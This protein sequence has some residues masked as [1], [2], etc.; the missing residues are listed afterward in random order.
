[1]DFPFRKHSNKNKK[2]YARKFHM[3]TVKFK[4]SSPP[5]SPSES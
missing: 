5:V 1:M 3:R 4:P 2:G